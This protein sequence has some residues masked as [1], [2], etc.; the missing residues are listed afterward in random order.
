M[1]GTRVDNLLGELR[2]HMPQLEKACVATF[3]G[4]PWCH[5]CPP[6]PRSP[7]RAQP[8]SSITHVPVCLPVPTASP[9]ASFR[10]S[11]PIRIA[12][13]HLDNQESLMENHPSGGIAL[14]L[15]T[16]G[17]GTAFPLCSWGPF[18]QPAPSREGGAKDPTVTLGNV[19][20]L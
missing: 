2:A 12:P 18:C 19:A 16:T 5:T 6:W 8:V 7:W 3:P 1:Q 10:P 9:Q 20:A 17:L 13:A 15:R 11:R 14:R 4:W